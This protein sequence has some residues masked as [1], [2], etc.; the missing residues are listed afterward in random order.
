MIQSLRIQN[1]VLIE[2]L[3]ISFHSGM[4]VLSGETGAGKSIVVDAVNLV[5]GGRADRSLIRSG[6]DKAIVEAVFDVPNRS[7]ITDILSREK[8]DF[9]GSTVSVYREMTSGGKN[10]CRICGIIVPVSLLKEIGCLLM[11]IHGQHEHQFLMSPD[12]HLMFLDHMGNDLYI[13][14]LRQTAEACQDFMNTHRNYVKLRKENEQKKQRM[15]FLEKELH[16]LQQA[17][18]KQGEEERLKE[19]SL[20]LR[21]AEKIRTTLQAARDHITNSFAEQSSLES[22]KDAANALKSLSHFDN[23]I[24]K[25]AESCENT[26]YELE[27]IAYELNEFLERSDT[28]PFEL[29]KVESRLDL[30]RR[31]ERKYGESIEKVLKTQS[32]MESEYQKLCSLEDEIDIT[33]QLHKQ[34]LAAYRQQ[35]RKM[36]EMRKNLALTV[37]RRMMEQ[38]KDLGME[39][40]TFQIRFQNPEGEK[41]PLPQ[42]AGD[43]K[44][45]FM[46]STNPGEPMKSLAKIASGGE[47][48]RFMLALKVLETE[49]NGIDCMVFDEIDTGISGRMAQVVAEKMVSISRFRQVIC[50]THLPQIAAAAD[51]QF[52]IS[53]HVTD[54]RTYT[55]VKEL[56]REERIEEVARMIS[57]AEGSASDAEAY[58]R[59]MIDASER[60]KDC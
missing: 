30:I 60:M 23:D 10:L 34:Q 8:I 11:D 42:P 51:H 20:K 36:T 1:I 21:N 3:T 39:K 28:D 25:I 45:E 16:D 33:A 53:K 44:L 40:T 4:Q 13:K 48:S 18:L 2:D 38:L 41:R 22:I 6:C 49:G 12:M 37:E 55:S 32:E 59:S 19:Q 54:Q 17:N 35:A 31:M 57:G 43:D 24:K 58:A 29:E 5:L 46:V 15:L 26:Y 9:D 14:Q 47:L 50:V 56:N 27:E 52:Y 7:D